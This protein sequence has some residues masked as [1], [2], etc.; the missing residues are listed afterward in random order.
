MAKKIYLSKTMIVNLVALIALIAQMQ[1][2]FIIPAEEQA[3]IL[4]V[5]NMALRFVTGESLEA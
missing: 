4:V 1:T 3:A 5:I 2:G